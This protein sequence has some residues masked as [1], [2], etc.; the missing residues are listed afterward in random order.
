M[1]NATDMCSM[2]TH[3]NLTKDPKLEA[4]RRDLERAISGVDIE[5]VKEDAGVREDVKG[6]LDSILKSYEW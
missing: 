3:L 5:D 4:A 1:T 6:K 2:L